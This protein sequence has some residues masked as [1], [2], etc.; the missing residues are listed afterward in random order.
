MG[1][2]N[3][4]R[5][6]G[7]I[8]LTTT[9]SEL[10]GWMLIFGAM[11]KSAASA[12]GSARWGLQPLLFGHTRWLQTM[13]SEPSQWTDLEVGVWPAPDLNQQS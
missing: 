4:P 1:F 2:L 7:L 3:N 9:V 10:I 13:S 5:L 8:R 12:A 11:M 6:H